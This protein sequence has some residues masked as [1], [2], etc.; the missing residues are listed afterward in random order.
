MPFENAYLPL[1]STLEVDIKGALCISGSI[2]VIPEMTV[3]E[4]NRIARL[5]ILSTGFPMKCSTMPALHRF[6]ENCQLDPT[7]LGFAY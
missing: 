5:T 7:F 4:S 2:V 6:V 3:M 1:R